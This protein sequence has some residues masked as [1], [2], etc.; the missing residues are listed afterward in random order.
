MQHLLRVF[1][2]L[3]QAHVALGLTPP[4][5]CVH[6]KSSLSV[7]W[8]LMSRLYGVWG[9]EQQKHFQH[10]LARHSWSSNGDSNQIMKC[11]QHECLHLRLACYFAILI[12]VHS[13]SCGSVCISSGVGEH[14][15]SPW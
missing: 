10:I 7:C 12:L 4:K 5:Y 6:V 3:P 15:V 8:S 11:S 9:P 1:Q 13:V 14:S 2:E